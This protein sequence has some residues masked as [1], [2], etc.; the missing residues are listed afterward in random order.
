MSKL[1]GTKVLVARLH[2]AT[3]I[4][5][6]GN[7]GPLIDR[8]TKGVKS[9]DLKLSYLDGGVLVENKEGT[10]RALIPTGNIASVEFESEK[11]SKTTV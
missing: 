8:N 9:G 7:I 2:T 4:T 5:N 10:V 11:N 6:V 1:N 3:H